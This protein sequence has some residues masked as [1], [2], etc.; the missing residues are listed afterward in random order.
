MIKT[1]PDEQKYPLVAFFHYNCYETSK[2]ITVAKLLF[3]HSERKSLLWNGFGQVTPENADSPLNTHYLPKFFFFSSWVCSSS[4]L[5]QYW[6]TSSKTLLNWSCINWLINNDVNTFIIF[7]V[8]HRW[9][10]MYLPS[11]QTSS[12][13]PEKKR[14]PASSRK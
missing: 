6:Q 4:K 9:G 7:D 14:T 5:V 2:H 12:S 3:P 13:F 8:K 11:W 1:F 10:E